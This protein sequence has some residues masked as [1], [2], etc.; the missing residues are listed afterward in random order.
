MLS[1]FSVHNG[2]APKELPKA[3]RLLVDLSAAISADFDLA[4]EQDEQQISFV[5]SVWVDNS[6]SPRRLDI[7]IQGLPQTIKI[8][9]GAIAC[10]PIIH[11]GHLRGTFSISAVTPLAIPVIFLNVPMAAIVYLP[12]VV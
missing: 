12:G 7:V 2:L 5:Q 6:A 8:P 1:G 9:I 11:P 3:I 4:K 10:L